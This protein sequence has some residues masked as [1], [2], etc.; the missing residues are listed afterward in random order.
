MI[1]GNGTDNWSEGDKFMAKEQSIKG[2]ISRHVQATTKTGKEK[3]VMINE[4]K[5]QPKQRY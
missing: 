4:K 5:G 2:H 3:K 1:R